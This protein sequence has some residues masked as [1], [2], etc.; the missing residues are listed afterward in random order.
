MCSKVKFTDNLI[1]DTQASLE[2]ASIIFQFFLAEAAK[3]SGAMSLG[4]CLL[5]HG[6]S[7]KGVFTPFGHSKW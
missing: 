6:A 5:I 4:F 2:R 7:Q 3:M 1:L